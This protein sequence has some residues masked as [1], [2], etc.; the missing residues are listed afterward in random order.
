MTTAARFYLNVQAT[1]RSVPEVD[2]WLTV[3]TDGERVK[4]VR[5]KGSP[6]KNF[7][8]RATPGNGILPLVKD[9]LKACPE[10]Y[11]VTLTTRR[12]HDWVSLSLEVAETL[13]RV[14][15]ALFGTAYKR[16]KEVALVTYA[17][18]ERSENEGLHT[19]VVI[20]VPEGSMS[21]KPNRPAA[22]VPE[23]VISTWTSLDPQNRRRVGQDAQEVDFLAGVVGYVEKRIRNLQGV[24]NVD[25]LNCY[26]PKTDRLSQPH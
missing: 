2:A 17:V 20:G 13:H 7:R 1:R 22:S 24:T 21:I 3:A 19:H 25:F 4:P 26:N 8:R 15:T 6:P 23:L 14:N 10:R 16:R 11:F 9:A 5:A 12:R 18:Q